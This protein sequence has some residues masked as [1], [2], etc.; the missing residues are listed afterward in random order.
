MPTPA[1]PELSAHARSL[2]GTPLTEL[3]AREPDR[4]QRMSFIWDD[5]L[6]DLSKERIGSDTL[7]LLVT[8]ATAA[9]LPGWISA[10]FA[11]EK[12]NLSEA[13]P[14]LHTALRQVGDAP[15]PVDGTD[16]IP[17][18]RAAQARMK[19]LVAQ[20]R[21]GLRVGAT[22]RPIRAVVNLGIGGSDLGPLLVCSALAAPP[23]AR[24]GA[25]P[26]TEGVDVSFV[27]NVDPE[28]LTHALAP[29]D[30]A[31]TL[32][33]VTSKTF[34]T[35]ETL[36][37]AASARG[38]LGAALGRG[39]EVGAHF[40]AVTGNAAAGAG[41]RRR[42]PRHPSA[43][44]LGRRPLFAVVTGRA[45]D[46]AEARVGPVSAAARR[47]REPRCALSH[48]ALRAQPA[49]VARSRR[50]V[51]HDAAPPCRARRRALCADALPTAGLSPAAGAG[52][53]R[54]AR[55]P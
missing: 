24:G 4:Q 37:N 46:R 23:R 34:T 48:D 44:G 9:G 39:V 41:V 36:A 35:Q 16:I 7:S 30:P 10:L 26:Q 17:V 47:R 1:I 25:G 43:V 5:W 12:V 20:I 6:V 3:F 53:Q 13:R 38:W 49:R 11:G 14:A 29:L 21:G 51:E 2:A 15:L 8:H 42:D 18:I 50:L 27:A 33:I 31:T 45:P 32:F 22:G 28:H 52:K 54:Q 55:R 40:L 19:T